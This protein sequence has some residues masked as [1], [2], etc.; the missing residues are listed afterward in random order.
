[1]KAKK[2]MKIRTVLLYVTLKVV[3]VRLARSLINVRNVGK[4]FTLARN[5]KN[6]KKFI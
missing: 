3:N 1:M 5:L 6:I 2:V 4:V